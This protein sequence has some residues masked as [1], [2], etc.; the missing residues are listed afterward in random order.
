MESRGEASWVSYEKVAQHLLHSIASE[1]DLGRVEGKQ[2]APGKSG[3]NWEIDA[4]GIRFSDEGFI[5]I[6]CRRYTTSRL[7]QEDVAAIAYRIKDMGAKG[8]IIVSPLNLQEGAR[9]VAE[10]EGLIHCRLSPNST[11]TDYVL[12]FL[13]KAFIGLSE[14]LPTMRD[15]LSVTVTRAPCNTGNHDACAGECACFCHDGLA[16]GPPATHVV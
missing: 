16:Y 9:K 2:I 11:T 4:K 8:G 13:N 3:T 12:Q 5:I 10:H 7:S 14:T 1:F 6:E 15:T